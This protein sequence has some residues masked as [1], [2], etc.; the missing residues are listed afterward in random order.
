MNIKYSRYAD[1]LLFSSESPFLHSDRFIKTIGCIL[2][3]R[4]F[5]INS[6]KTLKQVGVL[7]ING[8]IVGE[9][10][11]ISRRKLKNL[12]HVLFIVE[13]EKSKATKTSWNAP[14]FKLLNYLC[15]YRSYLIQLQRY[16]DSHQREKIKRTIH[17]IETVIDKYY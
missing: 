10:V 8:Y 15:G 9:T 7:N 13:K 3:D 4:D 14:N 1:D 12:N 2:S 6:K 11:G 16:G 17:R 5:T